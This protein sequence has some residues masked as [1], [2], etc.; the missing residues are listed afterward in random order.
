MSFFGILYIS[1][2]SVVRTLCA[3]AVPKGVTVGWLIT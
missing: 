2:H 3:Y 1:L